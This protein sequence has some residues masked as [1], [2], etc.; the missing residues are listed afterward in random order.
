MSTDTRLHALDAVRA[1]A[2]L[3]GIV[4]HGTMSFFLPIPAM[5]VSQ[6]TTL[7]I[8]FYIIHIFRMTT[9]F[10]IAGF[11]AHL[12]Y[13]RR[14][15]RMFARDRL[16][17]IALPLLIG[18]M[19]LAPLLGA[20]VI[21]GLTRTFGDVADLPTDDAVP[22]DQGFPLTHL[23]FLYYL[24]IFYVTFIVLREVIVRG[25]DRSGRIRRGV[26]RVTGRLLPA[27]LAPVVLGLPTA[28]VLYS[29]ADWQPWF[30][31][32][33]P[34]TGLA[35]QAQAMVAYGG[36]FVLGWLLHRQPGILESWR[37]RWAGR[38]AVAMGLTVVALL[39]VGT[40]ATQFDPFADRAAWQ[41]PVYA[42]CYASAIWFW[43]FGLVGA[44]IQF[45]SHASHVWRYL[46]DASYWM[47][48]AHLPIVF[49]LQVVL[50]PVPLHW[51]IKYPVILAVTTAI[52][53]L[54]YHYLVRSSFVGA[55]LNGRRS[56]RQAVT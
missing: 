11:F 43:T 31:I 24:C 9:F 29:S 7:G 37:Q 16:R 52:L 44:A 34:D 45:F 10:L 38:L 27:F 3:L 23:W 49:F 8:T 35:P 39:L 6:S 46:A 53:L 41:K 33:T 4:L 26:D 30:G 40:T 48:L 32:T 15:W 47:Y 20:I 21:W 55:T 17:R 14:G 19:I 25:M 28:W 51:S 2:L 1:T 13:H 54:S 36:A 22:G 12:V 50:A 5:D 42:L 18:W 56:P